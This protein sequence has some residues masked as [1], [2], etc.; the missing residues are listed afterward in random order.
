MVCVHLALLLAAAF[1]ILTAAAA[2]ADSIN[3]RLL[4][5]SEQIRQ[6]QPVSHSPSTPC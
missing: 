1:G 4:T 5:F 6:R 3:D 2:T